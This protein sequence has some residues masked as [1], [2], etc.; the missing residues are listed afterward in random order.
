M[1]SIKAIGGKAYQ[2]KYVES[3]TEFCIETLMPRM[4]LLD[5]TI[6]LSSPKGVM[7]Y[8]Q[9]LEDNRTFEIEINRK[10][11]LRKMLETVA[12]EMV[13]VKQYA[14][15]ELGHDYKWRGKTYSQKK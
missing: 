4:R 7:G 14:R 2:R 15:R 12:H 11:T 8:C 5:I 9:E 6:N 3:I 10:L 13:H 1:N